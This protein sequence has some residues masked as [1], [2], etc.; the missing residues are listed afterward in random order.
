MPAVLDDVTSQSELTT[1]DILQ[2]TKKN[3]YPCVS[4]SMLPLLN[5][6]H[7]MPSPS[8]QPEFLCSPLVLSPISFRSLTIL[9]IER[10]LA[11]YLCTSL[12]KKMHFYNFYLSAILILC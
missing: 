4:S 6:P 1:T 3:D 5:F 2:E 10:D 9:C 12:R 8:V 7:Q 11:C